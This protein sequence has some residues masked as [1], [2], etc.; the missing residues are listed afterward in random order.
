MKLSPKISVPQRMRRRYSE[1]GLTLIEL[2]V[3]LVVLIALAGILIPQLPNMITRSH[4]T[5]ASTNIGEANKIVQSFEQIYFKDP[6]KLDN[7][8]PGAT[9][10]NLIDY[11]PN[12]T[13]PVTTTAAGGTITV[14]AL[15]AGEAAALTTAG[16]D[17]V[18]N[19][20]ADKATIDTTTDASTTFNPYVTAT[21]TVAVASGSVVASIDPAAIQTTLR[22]NAL[23]TDV[24]VAFG[25]GQN[26]EMTGNVL[27]TA[28]YHFDDDQTALPSDKYVRFL[29]VYKVAN[30]AGALEK[31][32]FAGVIAMHSDG[33]VAAGSEVG[34]FFNSNKLN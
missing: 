16:I 29:A 6:A 31:A 21:P 30:A 32:Q 5:A 23:A 34:E 4:T 25:I 17:T 11:L 14:H 1:A 15:T 22:P 2:L 8:V 19:L 18:S 20:I 26:S 3:V 10:S 9:G 7:L 24:F 12:S 28:P 27:S 33:V 13:G